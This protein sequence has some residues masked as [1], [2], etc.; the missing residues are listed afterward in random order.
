[1]LRLALAAVLALAVGVSAAP[2][3]RGVAQPNIVV[4][5]TDDQ[6][7]ETMPVMRNVRHLL[8]EKGTTFDNSFTSFPL[9][10]PSRASFLT[11]QY[12]HNTRVLGNNIANGLAR[13]DQTRT[14]P[15]WLSAAGYRTAFVGKYLNEYR[16]LQGRTTPP[17]WNDWNAGLSLSYFNHTM[18]RNGRVVR[19]GSAATDYQSDV[20]TR[21]AVESIAETAPSQP[22]FMWLSYF[23]PHYGGP[24][25]PGD[26]VTL[27]STVAAPRHRAKFPNVTLPRDPSFNEADVSDKPAAIRA[28]P[29][30]GEGN[31]AEMTQTYRK[32]LQSLL[33][34]DEGVAKVVAALKRSGRLDNTLILF[35]SDNGWLQGQHRIENAKELPY[36]PSIR[37]PLVVRGPG[38]P[39]N[40]HLPQLVMN[41]DLAPTILEAA[42]V[43]PGLVQDGRSLLPLLGAP[44]TV[45][46]RDILLERGP[47]GNKTGA[48]RLYTGVRTQRYV[49]LEHSS[50]ERE[51]YDLQVDPFQLESKHDDPAFA[52]VQADLAARLARLRDCTGL[53]CQQDF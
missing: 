46:N 51:L 26:P 23:A 24:L 42:R 9:C 40:A 10:C 35:T 29:P 34:V 53:A 27:K 33:S 18:N 52:A 43:S 47:G 5:M 25:E 21:I 20:Y 36:E 31:L 15:V 41:V 37:V 30:L 3:K 44:A 22:L 6:S 38:V 17:G 28:R 16:R 1:M 12:A 32:R 48:T 11:G 45:W 4:I 14:L 39:V 2:A 8:A 50:G 13:F 7:V 49:Y 19:F